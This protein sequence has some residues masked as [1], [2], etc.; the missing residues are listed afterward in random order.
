MGD[1][2]KLLE[3]KAKLHHCDSLDV[4][5]PARIKDEPTQRTVVV[6][7]V[8]TYIL[9]GVASILF[10]LLCFIIGYWCYKWLHQKGANRSLIFVFSET[11]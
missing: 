1:L 8:V 4:P 11:E 7:K 9:S 5:L 6:S 3:P 2:V 10:L